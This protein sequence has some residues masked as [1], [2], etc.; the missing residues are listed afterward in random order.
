MSDQSAFDANHIKEVAVSE[1]SGV[2]DQLNLPPGLI[3]FLR[4]NQRTIWIVVAVIATVVTVVALYDSYR[5]YQENKAVSAYDAALQATGQEKRDRLAALAE[6]YGSTHIAPWAMI[7]LARMDSDEGNIDAALGQLD[8]VNKLTGHKN[9]LKPLVLYRIAGLDEEKKDLGQ[10]VPLYQELAA[11]PGFEADAHYAL[12]RI[13]AVQGK[14]AEALTE[15]QQYLSL[16]EKAGTANTDP[17]KDLV[18]YAMKAL[19]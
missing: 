5:T 15:Y 11:F 2:L 10:A 19:K 12:G 14:K 3:R 16:V 18:E 17:R 9:P 4:K 6:Q 8:K 7:E 13:Y 1:T